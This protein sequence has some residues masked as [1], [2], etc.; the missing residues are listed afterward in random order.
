MDDNAHSSDEERFSLQYGDAVVAFGGPQVDAELSD[1]RWQ[2][3]YSDLVYKLFQPD[4]G[5]RRSTRLPGR[6]VT[7]IA[8]RPDLRDDYYL[9][10]DGQRVVVIERNT[11]P[12]GKSTPEIQG[13]QLV[14]AREALIHCGAYSLFLASKYSI[15]GCN[16]SEP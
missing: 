15:A 6:I 9:S 12:R 14:S 7:A 1:P 3:D 13:W 5:S 2:P 16:E 4:H 8:A 10:P 11:V